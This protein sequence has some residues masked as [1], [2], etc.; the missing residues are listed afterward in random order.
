MK[1]NCYCKDK[2]VIELIEEAKTETR[3]EIENALKQVI[4]GAPGRV[5]LLPPNVEKVVGYIHEPELGDVAY[6]GKEI[7]LQALIDE[8]INLAFFTRTNKT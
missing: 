8:A 3:N 7:D 4:Q 2:G 5:F 6:N 1:E